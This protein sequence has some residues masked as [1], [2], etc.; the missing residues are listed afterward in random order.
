MKTKCL[1]TKG[2][3]SNSAHGG[4]GPSEYKKLLQIDIEHE[5]TKMK[6]NDAKKN[7]LK[8]SLGSFV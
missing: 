2:S 5:W 6:V 8:I 3:H 1:K 4:F 7:C